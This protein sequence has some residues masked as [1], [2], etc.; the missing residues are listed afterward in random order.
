MDGWLVLQA[1]TDQTGNGWLWIAATPF[2]GDDGLEK[3]K[4]YLEHVVR[5]EWQTQFLDGDELK[6]LADHKGVVWPLGSIRHS[7]IYYSDDGMEAWDSENCGQGFARRITIVKMKEGE[8]V[9]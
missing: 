5:D 8:R 3:A 4:A 7:D 1:E 6:K 2:S 9:C